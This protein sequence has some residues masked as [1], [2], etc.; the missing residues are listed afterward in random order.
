PKQLTYSTTGVYDHH[1]SP[2]GKNLTYT[3]QEMGQI[4]PLRMPSAG[5]DSEIVLDAAASLDGAPVYSF[6]GKRI[7]VATVTSPEHGPEI[8]RTVIID[9]RTNA[10][11][12]TIEGQYYSFTPDGTGLIFIGKHRGTNNLMVRPLRKGTPYPLTTLRNEEAY[13]FAISSDGKQLAVV[14][15][16]DEADAVLISNFR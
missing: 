4:R 13:A 2:D 5:G 11:L 6:D 3:N 14:H 15:A 12:Q 8:R 7:M 1:L 16:K 9:A 10:R